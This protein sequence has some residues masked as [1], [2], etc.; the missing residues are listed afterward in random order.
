MGYRVKLVLFSDLHLD[1]RFSWLGADADAARSR[2]LA[3]RQTLRGIT[4]LA[5]DLNA[6][7]L[8]CGGD[9]YEHERISPDTAGFLRET[10][11]EL[12]G[13]P[14]YLAPGN[15]DWYSPQSAYAQIEW[16]GNVHVFHQAQFQPVKLGPDVTLWGAAHT[17]PTTPGSLLDGFSAP[18]EGIHL[19]LFHGSE[20]GWQLGEEGMDVHAPFAAEDVRRAG[21][22]HA[23]LG[24]FHTPRE[25]PTHTYPGNPDPLSFGE[26][27][28][29]GAVEIDVRPDGTLTR[30]WHAVTQTAVKD[31]R[32]DVTGCA[33]QDAV[34]RRIADAVG[35]APCFA[36]ATLQGDI[37]PDVDLH[38]RDLATA[39][40]WLHGLSI[41]LGALHP[42]YD[43]EAL[44]QERTV[45]GAFVRD[46]R[47]TIEDPDEQRRVLVTGL[48]A[49]A[50]RTDLEVR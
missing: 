20:R 18:R 40:P 14:A 47:E 2:R 23:F 5:R 27:G 50:G 44:A 49:L 29:R 31:V 15:H 12:D 1:S 4:S 36:R 8:L 25:A 41:Q 33:S 42:A 28:V 13:I 30:H 17:A 16:P 7:A 24:H 22:H 21:F 46:V 9:L 48:R 32:V 11:A 37:H 35:S 39:A 19:A 3:L 26:A 10:F 6:D 45:R 34:R 38:V 43:F